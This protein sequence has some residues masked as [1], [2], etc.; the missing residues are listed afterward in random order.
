MFD[1]NTK[2]ILIECLNKRIRLHEDVPGA[3]GATGSW[4][5]P[6]PRQISGVTGG[7]T[8]P[9]DFSTYNKPT[10][11]GGG[12]TGACGPLPYSGN[13]G[14]GIKAPMDIPGAKGPGEFVDVTGTVF[15]GMGAG[16]I[17]TTGALAAGSMMGKAGAGVL[18]ALGSKFG[19]SSAG[20]MN[21]K[22]GQFGSLLANSKY[23]QQFTQNLAALAGGERAAETLADMPRRSANILVQNLGY[24][25]EGSWAEQGQYKKPETQTAMQQGQG[26]IQKDKFCDEYLARYGKKGPGCP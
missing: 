6:T 15:G 12:P 14:V 13:A 9:P 18:G 23:G 10:T 7:A 1:K 21:S 19:I 3:T 11:L 5:P 25:P 17:A 2:C 8:P 16:D 22:F 26:Q 24:T 4:T 20:M